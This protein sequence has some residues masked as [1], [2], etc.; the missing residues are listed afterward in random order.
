MPHVGHVGQ[1]ML[2]FSGK[3][4]FTPSGEFS[5]SSIHHTCTLHNVPAED[6]VYGLITLGC[7]PG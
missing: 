3:P 6:Y 2:T 1:E 7:S 4:G 5:M